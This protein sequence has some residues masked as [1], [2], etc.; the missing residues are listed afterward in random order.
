MEGKPVILV[1]D[2]D[3]PIQLLM[4]SLLREF[5]FEP[6]TAGSGDKA[7]E[8]VRGGLHPDLVLLDMNMPGMSGPDALR[9]LRVLLAEVPIVI[10]SGERLTPSEIKALGATGAVQKPFD[11]PELVAQIRGYVS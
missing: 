11:V 1:V 10:L 2:D 7:L 9:E 4:Q 6:V 3:V 5:G 8:A